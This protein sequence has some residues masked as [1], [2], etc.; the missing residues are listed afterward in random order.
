MVVE[1]RKDSIK[2]YN[3]ENREDIAVA[4]WFYDKMKGKDKKRYYQDNRQ[5]IVEQSKKKYDEEKER[6]ANEKK[7]KQ[8]LYLKKKLEKQA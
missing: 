4:Q 6:Q 5:K 7:H 2:K 8:N 3:R 1:K